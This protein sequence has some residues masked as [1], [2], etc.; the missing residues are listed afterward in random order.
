MTLVMTL[1]FF[2]KGLYPMSLP[3]N[4]FGSMLHLMDIAIF[5]VT[6]G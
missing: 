4:G 6:A 2:Q 5:T 1:I 3:E